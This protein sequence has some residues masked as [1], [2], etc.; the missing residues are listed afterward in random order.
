[1]SHA[2]AASGRGGRHVPPRPAVVA[3]IAV[4]PAAVAVS[5]L[6]LVLGASLEGDSA[7]RLNRAL[8]YWTGVP[9]L[10][11]MAAGLRWRRWPAGAAFVYVHAATAA[12]IAIERAA[13]ALWTPIPVDWGADFVLIL[14]APYFFGVLTAGLLP[15]LLPLGGCLLLAW[16]SL[17]SASGEKTEARNR[18]LHRIGFVALATL[19]QVVASYAAWLLMH[20]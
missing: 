16:R 17:G 2:L 7:V 3:L 8:A 1:M 13:T 10:V 15:P 14:A 6:L 18:R 4:W 11:W 5:W 12:L 20:A 19:W 9:A